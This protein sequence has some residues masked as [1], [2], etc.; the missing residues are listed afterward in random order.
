[1]GI[2]S[3]ITATFSDWYDDRAQRMGAALA[4]YTVF[5]LAPGV[6]LIVA[7]AGL[8][9]GRDIAQEQFVEQ[10]GYVLG[11]EGAR[12]I[13]AMIVS[14]RRQAVGT[15]A[16]LL[17]AGTLLFGLWGVFGE[18]QDALN[19]IWGVAPKPGRGILQ[20]VK[21]RFLSFAMVTGI[22]F[23]LLVS[24]AVSAWLAA[25]G[26]FFSYLLPA[27]EMVLKAIDV[28]VS[29]LVITVLF[30]LTFK[31][32]PDVEVAWRDVFVG[33][34]VTSLLFVIG[35]SL[36]GL[37]LGKSSIGSVYGAAGSLVVILVWVYYSSQIV[38]LGAEFTKVWARRHGRGVVV[39]E[40]AVPLTTEA[41][42]EQGMGRRDAV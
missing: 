15:T 36:I 1:M 23:L 18:L 37:Y 38:I 39:D 35:K 20:M 31:L 7:V 8:G 3:L 29:V 16:A 28:S 13:D 32:L 11:A 14:A 22:G 19:T 30:A 42:R 10:L 41:R 27:P 2:W 5:A 25:V 6:L 34:G 33:A 17:A 24:L 4:Y 21:D 26:K 12:A 9:F 40:D